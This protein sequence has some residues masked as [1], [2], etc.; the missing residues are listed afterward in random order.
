[1][2]LKTEYIR[3]PS[4]SISLL[5]GLVQFFQLSI[6]VWVYPIIKIP[7]KLASLLSCNE[8]LQNEFSLWEAFFLKRYYKC[9]LYTFQTTDENTLTMKEA[10]LKAKEEA[11]SFIEM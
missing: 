3:L 7:R 6:R 11:H 9:S 2:K 4:L 1:M 5:H 8:I 10:H